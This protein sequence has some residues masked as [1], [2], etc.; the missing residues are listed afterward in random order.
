MSVVL[1][2]AFCMNIA[3]RNSKVLRSSFLKLH[4]SSFPW[5]LQHSPVPTHLSIRKLLWCRLKFLTEQECP[6]THRGCQTVFSLQ[7]PCWGVIFHYRRVVRFFLSTCVPESTNNVGTCSLSPAR[8][9]RSRLC[10]PVCCNML[11]LSLISGGSLQLMCC[12]NG[13]SRISS[14]T[15][16]CQ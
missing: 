4:N 12:R 13:N 5:V 8:S 2:C 6:P 10:S 9:S 14:S 3:L 15:R 1:M 11:L 16:R 7:I